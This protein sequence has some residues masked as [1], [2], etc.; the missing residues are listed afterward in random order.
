MWETVSTGQKP[1]VTARQV[2]EWLNIP[3]HAA[4]H[5]GNNALNRFTAFDT[6]GCPDWFKRNSIKL[7]VEE[8][9]RECYKATLSG[10][11]HFAQGDNSPWGFYANQP[12]ERDAH[13]IEDGVVECIEQAIGVDGDGAGNLSRTDPVFDHL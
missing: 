11:G 6:S 8:W 9:M 2:A 4:S 3:L 7:E 1:Q 13:G 10:V 12:T 5:A